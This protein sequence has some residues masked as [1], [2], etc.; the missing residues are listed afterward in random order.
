MVVGGVDSCKEKLSMFM[1]HLS[2]RILFWNEWRKKTEGKRL[3]QVHMENKG[4]VNGVQIVC[5]VSRTNRKSFT[6]LNKDC[7]E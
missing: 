4:G 7:R 5:V 1:C 2:S 6:Q 3:T